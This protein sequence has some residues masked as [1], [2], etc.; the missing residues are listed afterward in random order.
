[1]IDRIVRRPHPL[2]GGNGHHEG[3]ARLQLGRDRG[4]SS[5]IVIDMLDHVERADKV[6]MP[7]R[8]FRELGKR[9]AHDLAAEPFLRK[10]ASLIVQFQSFDMAELTEHREIM[11]GA[12]SDLENRG[13]ARKPAFPADE[14]G[15]D[16][17]ARAIPPVTVIELGHLLINNTFHQRKTS[18]R[19][20]RKVASGVTK[21]AGTSGHQVGPW[22]GPVST[23]VN[24]SLRKNPDS[25]T[26]RNLTFNRLSSRRPWPRKL[27]RL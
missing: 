12:T 6:V 13:I 23:H 22:S 9:R 20:R 17:A 1:M 10:C 8:D 3:A 7:I 19:L 27:H 14:I 2:M 18:W 11:A 24:A 5:L 4:K 16:L 15:D 21:I 26:N 25:W